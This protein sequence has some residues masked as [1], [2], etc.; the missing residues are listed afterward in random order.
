MVHSKTGTRIGLVAIS[1]ERPAI[2]DPDEQ[3][4]RE[5]LFRRL[6]RPFAP[7]KT[8]ERGRQIALQ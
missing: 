1:D 5:Y 6:E 2:H 4:N 7:S 8:W 3:H